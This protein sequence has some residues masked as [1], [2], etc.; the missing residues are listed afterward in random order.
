M[1]KAATKLHHADESFQPEHFSFS[2]EN[3]ITAQAHIAKYPEGK[4]QSAVM[5]LLTLAQKQ[6]NNWLPTA[7]MDVVAKMLGMP[8]IRVYEVAT[9][10]SMYNLKP[11][12]EH[13]V[14]VCTT[15]P[16]WLRGSEDVMNACKKKLGVGNGGTTA[17]GKFTLQEVE[18][19][20]ACVNAPM[21]QVTSHD[22]R[23]EYYEDLTAEG[24]EQLLNAL[25]IGVEIQPGPQSGRQSS[26]PMEAK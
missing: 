22:G 25:E 1:D 20:G 17:D 14:Q 9:F 15:T 4:Q 21:I 12:G 23:D 3:F 16:C 6:N 11:V 13:H 24:M 18:C 2:E 7:A 5:P 19:L 26:E 8:P 10:Y